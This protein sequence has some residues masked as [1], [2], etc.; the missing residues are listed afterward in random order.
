[1]KIAST[2]FAAFTT[3]LTIGVHFTSSFTPSF[4]VG[5][6]NHVQR[7]IKTSLNNDVA[8]NATTGEVTKAQHESIQ[9]MRSKMSVTRGEDNKV[10]IC[11]YM[12]ACMVVH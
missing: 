5:P 2:V 7:G 10:C 6:R 9:E 1:M 12:Y 3:T 4:L 11:V 8:A